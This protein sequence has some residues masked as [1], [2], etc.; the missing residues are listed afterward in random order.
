MVRQR[1]NLLSFVLCFAPALEQRNVDVSRVNCFVSGPESAEDMM[2]LDVM[3]G[4]WKKPPL[5]PPKALKH[6][7]WTG[8]EG[9]I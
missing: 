1:W 9:Y 3:Y 6:T 4:N 2:T 5:R 8:Q 7:V